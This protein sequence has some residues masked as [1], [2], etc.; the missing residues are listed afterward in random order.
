MLMSVFLAFM[1]IGNFFIEFFSQKNEFELANI[2]Q[3]PTAQRTVRLNR[4]GAM[5]GIRST[6]QQLQQDGT[7][8]LY[9]Y[10]QLLCRFVTELVLV[11][12]CDHIFRRIVGL[13]IFP[14]C[15]NRSAFFCILTR[16]CD[17]D[18]SEIR[19]KNI[20]KAQ[21]HMS[22]TCSKKLEPCFSDFSKLRITCLFFNSKSLDESKTKT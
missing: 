1:D 12:H 4:E 5:I 14:R 21:Q 3:L 11:S 15:K 7:T 9:K 20:N 17:S 6:Q 13:E 19:G 18:F 10:Y 8:V 2:Y 16:T 22:T